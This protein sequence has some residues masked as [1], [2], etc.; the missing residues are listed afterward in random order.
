MEKAIRSFLDEE[1]DSGEDHSPDRAVETLGVTSTPATLDRAQKH[2]RPKCSQSSKT[3]MSSLLWPDDIV[4]I[5][6]LLCRILLQA[7][8]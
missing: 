1:R 2:F 5:G 7:E 4:R 8:R 3:C 6:K